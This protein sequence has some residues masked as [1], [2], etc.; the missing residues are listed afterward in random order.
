MGSSGSGAA[1]RWWIRIE[2]P[3][4]SCPSGSR[5]A[6]RSRGTGN[7]RWA[8]RG[9]GG[10]RAWG[11]RGTRARGAERGVNEGEEA[12]REEARGAEA[13]GGNVPPPRGNGRRV[14]LFITFESMFASIEHRGGHRVGRP[15]R[16]GRVVHAGA[17]RI[18]AL[19][20]FM[21]AYLVFAF[22]RRNPS[23]GDAIGRSSRVERVAEASATGGGSVLALACRWRTSPDARS[24]SYRAMASIASVGISTLRAG[25]LRPAAL[26][27][28]TSAVGASPARASVI[29][30]ARPRRFD[31]SRG[32]HWRA[33]VTSSRDR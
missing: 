4:P 26:R 27:A 10:T 33:A 5:R 3:S 24:G 14:V 20:F 6:G 29:P 28:K 23:R 32:L 17:T 13:R 18:L 15:T 9:R 12:R 11:T 30:R 7:E 16:E 25:A 31:D 1:S 8:G 22:V 21:C 2:N 19:E